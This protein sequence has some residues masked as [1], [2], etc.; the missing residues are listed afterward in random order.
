VAQ[1]FTR[2]GG[3]AIDGCTA[4]HQGYA[5]SINSSKRIEQVFGWIK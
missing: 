5:Q 4:R 1:S 2:R 3:S